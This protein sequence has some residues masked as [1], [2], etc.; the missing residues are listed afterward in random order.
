VERIRLVD[1]AHHPLRLAR[2]HEL[3]ET[4]GSLDLVDDPVPVADRLQT[5][6]GAAPPHRARG[7]RLTAR[8]TLLERAPLMGQPLFADQPTVRPGHRG[9]GVMLVG[10]E[11]D[12]FHLLRLPSRLTPPSVS[13]THT[14]K[15]P[16]AEAQR[17]MPS[18]PRPDE[19]AV[20]PSAL[21]SGGIAPGLG[22]RV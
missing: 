4:A 21:R 10:I 20:D 3:G 17:F 22:P 14:V 13:L 5:P 11:R 2:V 6:P 15:R 12:I 9:Q 1:L 8:Q 16:C 18:K 7:A 19:P